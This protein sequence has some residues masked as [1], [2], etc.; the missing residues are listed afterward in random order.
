MQRSIS[1]MYFPRDFFE[2][3]IRICEENE[4]KASDVYPLRL[5]VC[6]VSV[7]VPTVYFS[8]PPSESTSKALAG[9]AS[10]CQ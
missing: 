6:A 3:R 8:D 10:N 4:N 5:K 9:F 2:K 1:R 7:A